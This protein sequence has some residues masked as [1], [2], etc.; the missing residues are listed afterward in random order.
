MRTIRA[1]I[2]GT[3]LSTSLLSGCGGSEPEKVEYKPTETSQFNDMSKAMMKNVQT[4]SYKGAAPTTPAAAPA[5][6]K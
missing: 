4:K 5:P 6:A 2:A 1:A 3:L